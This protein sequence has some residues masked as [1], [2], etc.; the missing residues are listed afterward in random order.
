MSTPISTIDG[1]TLIANGYEPILVAG[2]APVSENWQLGPI[3]IE[4]FN[5]M[6]DN[7]PEAT[8]IGLRTGNLIGVDI[9][10]RNLEHAK[11]IR[12]ITFKIFGISPLVRTGSKGFMV[13]YRTNE[14]FRKISVTTDS[15][16]KIEILGTG[17]QFVAFG[18]HPDTGGT[19]EWI[20]Q[21]DFDETANPCNTPLALLPAIDA[22]KIKEFSKECTSVLAG[23]GYPNPKIRRTEQLCGTGK[24]PNDVQEDDE[25]NIAYAVDALLSKVERREVAIIGQFGNDTIYE[26]AAFLID[27]YYL[28]EEKTID[29]MLK[30][31]YPH[32][33]PNTLEDECRAIISHVARYMQN[34]SGARATPRV[35]ALF[36]VA[37]DKAEPE[38][39]T[40]TTAGVCSDPSAKVGVEPSKGGSSPQPYPFSTPAAERVKNKAPIAW[41]ADVWYPKYLHGLHEGKGGSH[42]SRS[43][44]QDMIC[45]ANGLPI[46][47][48]ETLRPIRGVYVNWDT[49]ADE[50][51]RRLDEIPRALQRNIMEAPPSLTNIEVWDL[52]D[53]SEC[54]LNIGPENAANPQP[55]KFGQH[56]LDKIKGD[57]VFVV[58]DGIMD[59][60][61]FHAGLMNDDMTVRRV[62]SVMQRWCLT[63]NMTLHSILHPSRAGEK[64][65][66]GG[67]SMAASWFNRPR[68]MNHYSRIYNPNKTMPKG[69]KI[70]DPRITLS[71]LWV[72]RRIIKGP[73]GTEN[74][75][76]FLDYDRGALRPEPPVNQSFQP[77]EE[78]DYDW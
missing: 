37:L 76:M 50:L 13:A 2:K 70:T 53:S 36:R 59:A 67:Q 28:S 72:Q 10:V 17:L 23:F 21:T 61:C 41:L 19:Y 32:C 22:E 51:D 68:V 24:R 14:P 45:L 11:Q 18:I 75:R 9:D 48:Q 12:E 25:I 42:K 63:Y 57:H 65:G 16:T 35:S 33:V 20:G 29:L 3:T 5:A 40:F 49:P 52:S 73:A 71:D 1:A 8:G 30:H 66:E 69:W 54:F 34:E 27:N 43:L 31:W 78:P 64:T 60:V 6:R 44:A 7:H 74:Q 15:E 26:T 38:G 77:I 39:P 55:T 56:F 46:M 58:I 47:G 4:R 62:L